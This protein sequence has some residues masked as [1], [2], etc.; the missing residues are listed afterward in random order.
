VRERDCEAA[1]V[2]FRSLLVQNK[3]GWSA[4]LTMECST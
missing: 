3:H 2:L 1:G 4:L